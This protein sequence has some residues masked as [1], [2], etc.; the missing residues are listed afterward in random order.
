MTCLQ[1][2][3]GRVL[4][5]Q[6]LG[7]Q[8]RTFRMEA[9]RYFTLCVPFFM[10]KKNKKHMTFVWGIFIC[11]LSFSVFSV[12]GHLL[13]DRVGEKGLGLQSAAKPLS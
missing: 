6:F 10:K 7:Y 2:K 4:G 11:W 1:K 9:V 12:K 8:R 5:P 13:F 3:G